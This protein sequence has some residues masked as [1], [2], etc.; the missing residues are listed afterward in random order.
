MCTV[1]LPEL[2]CL[3][4]QLEKQ[5][6]GK[7]DWIVIHDKQSHYLLECRRCNDM[8][9]I[10]LPCSFNQMEAQMSTFRNDHNDCKAAKAH[11]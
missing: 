5:I 6:M 7:H 3:R 4:H 2:C 11:D 10:G 9:K 1:C 8:H